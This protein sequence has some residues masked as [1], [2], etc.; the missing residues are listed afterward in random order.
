MLALPDAHRRCGL[1][2]VLA[3]ALLAGGCAQQRYIRLREREQP[4]ATGPLGLLVR[5]EP[6]PTPRT[7]Q[8]LRRYDLVA[9]QE[10]SP[11]ATLARLAQEL[12]VDPSPDKICSYAELSFLDGQRQE[13]RGKPKDALDSYG[14]TV[15]H[16][17]WF[18][19]DPALDRFRNPYDPHFRRAC[20]LYNDA[21]SAAMRIVIKQNKLRP[22]E[23]Q[24]IQTGKKQFQVEVVLRGPWHPEDI[25]RL[26][27]VNDYEIEGGLTN[28]YHT[29]GL[30]V[31]LI[32]VRRQHADEATAERYY[33]PGL[34]FPV[35]AF[36]RVENQ[37]PQQSA[38]NIHR[39]T[40]ELYDPLFS[41]DI[42][43]C[44]RLVPLE[45]D[46]TVPLAFFLDNPA[47]KEKDLATLGLLNP[48][49]AQGIKGLYMVEPFDPNRIP[50][51]MVHGLWSSPTTWMEMFNDLRAFPEVRSRFQF[52]F[53]L[54]PTGQPFWVSA[55][56]MR[57]TLAEVRDTLDPQFRNP[58]LDQLVL[59][60]HSMG[61]L[62][63]TL[64]TIE[65]GDEFWQLLSKKPIEE[66][67]ATP[68]EKSRLAKSFYFHPNASVKRVVT[69]G[70]PHRGSTFANDWTRDLAR[71]WIE[72][73]EMM[74]ELGNRVALLNPGYFSNKDLL[75]MTTSIDSLAPDCPIFP[76]M[77]SAPR[78]SW[79]K[80]HNIVG[81]VPK[82]TFVGRVSEE[83]DGIV[84]YESAH[85]EYAA[86]EVAV[87]ADH[88]VVHRHP[89]AI[90]EVRRIL[91]E[92][93]ATAGGTA[94]FVSP[95]EEMHSSASSSPSSFTLH[96]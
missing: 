27:F 6:K 96:R 77:L 9:L 91:L 69:I 72:L 15:A 12:E 40:L 14:A 1:V 68:E 57:D 81:M 13:A 65:S 51:V 42:A 39:C 28:Q 60:G 22:G 4:F 7:L 87:E 75:T 95:A 82:R 44:N 85:V 63:S 56:Q 3:A 45:T 17:Y 34:C 38:A 19:L 64:Q 71:R 54:Y 43:V 16:A 94:T 78:A 49:K 83:G 74:L 24:V 53:F 21:L 5:K 37:T 93:L 59:V 11:E 10:K 86:T 66:L 23:T 26:E 8:L 88:L 35:T 47:F 32:A 18:L 92:H 2:L 30:G 25:D 48:N 41:S 58:N 84:S 55:A 31:P 90:L 67:R 33:P 73:P 52:W 36:L 61:G 80:F 50:V 70:T 20:D 46:L 79:T 29:Y 62:V 89:L 76:V